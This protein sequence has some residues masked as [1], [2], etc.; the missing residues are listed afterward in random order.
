MYDL[1]LKNGKVVFP[2]G[3]KVVDVCIK[4]GKIEKIMPSVKDLTKDVIDCSGFYVL[5]GII[6]AHVHMR[7][8][9]LTMKEDFG[10]GSRA[11]AAGGIT[12]FIDMPNTRPP[13]LNNDDL[14]E[15]RGFA[16][17][18][19]V[20]NFGF[21]IGANGKNFNDIK[22]VKNVAGV[23]VYFGAHYKDISIED[24]GLL[25][26]LFKWGKM[27]I[28]IHAESEKGSYEAV[29]QVL[30]IAKKYDA[31][32]HIAH[33]STDSEIEEIRKFKSEKVTCETAPHYLFL[34]KNAFQDLGNFAKVNPPLQTHEDQEALFKAIDDGVI[35]M[36]AT[37]H[38]PHLKEEKEKSFEEAPVG[39]PGVETLLPLML[40]IVNKGRIDIVKLVKLMC[41]N[42]A[43]IFDIKN[44]GKIAEGFDADLVIVDMDEKRIVRNENLFTK[45]GWS[46]FNEWE[47]QGV[48]KITIVN[49][50]KVFEN[51][52]IIAGD[53]RGGE[54]KFLQ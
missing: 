12:T 43:R 14:D 28:V 18:D 38:A 16:N 22:H 13:T 21:Y 48:P 6:D 53:F 33:V 47:L 31:R 36:I 7:T 52:K 49:G 15:K 24:A 27:P 1:I 46:P 4:D 42:P 51:G 37:D 23:K 32:V 3:V 54:V 45:C 34:N 11:C 10:T 39:V 41:E 30:H 19:S 5:P 2:D 29:K 35:E 40:D 9:G 17:D 26:E 25:E 44:K 8:P 20:V 50:I